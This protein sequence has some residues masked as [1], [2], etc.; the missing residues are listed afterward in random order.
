MAIVMEGAL[1]EPI[2][3]RE[4]MTD[5]LHQLLKLSELDNVTIQVVRSGSTEWTP[6]HAGP[7]ILFEFPK[8]AP[9]VHVEHLSSSAFLSNAGDVRTYSDAATNLRSAA[10]HPTDSAEFIATIA[11]EMEANA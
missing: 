8:A 3:G 9:I 5:Q 6:A 4:V 10:M 2:G 1:R 11:D 7:F